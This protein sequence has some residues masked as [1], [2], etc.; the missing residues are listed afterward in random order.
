MQQETSHINV[1]MKSLEECY[2]R[3]S[4]I[5]SIMKYL[6]QMIMLIKLQIQIVT[7]TDLT[8]AHKSSDY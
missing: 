1:E 5:I 8:K 6:I 3:I 7:I 2:D 4:K